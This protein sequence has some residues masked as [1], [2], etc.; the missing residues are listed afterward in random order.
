MSPFQRGLILGIAVGIGLHY[1]YVN[2]GRSTG[3]A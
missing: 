1:A 3:G 2:S